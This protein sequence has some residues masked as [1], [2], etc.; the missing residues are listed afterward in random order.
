MNLKRHHNYV[1]PTDN[2]VPYCELDKGNGTG[3]DSLANMC[4][5]FGMDL[6]HMG[7][8]VC[9]EA[10][11]CPVDIHIENYMVQHWCMFLHSSTETELA[12]T[13]S[14]LKLLQHIQMV[15]IHYHCIAPDTHTKCLIVIVH[16]L[17]M[18]GIRVDYHIDV[19]LLMLCCLFSHRIS[20]LQSIQMDNLRILMSP[21]KI[22]SLSYITIHIR[23]F[24]SLTCVL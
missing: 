7:W 9:N 2:F 14:V 3:Q 22:S 8:H 10:A 6:K 12:S 20:H 11:L 5:H 23:W 13:D 4:H 24:I 18:D 21:K 17:P 15:R 16:K 1:L 19:L